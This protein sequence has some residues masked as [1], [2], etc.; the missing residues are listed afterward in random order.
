MQRICEILNS[1]KN[2]QK[3][4]KLTLKKKNKIISPRSLLVSLSATREELRLIRRLR[5]VASAISGVKPAWRSLLGAMQPRS[6]L[7]CIGAIKGIYEQASWLGNF[8]QQEKR[9]FCAVCVANPREPV[10][11]SLIATAQQSGASISLIA[12]PFVCPSEERLRGEGDAVP[13]KKL[14]TFGRQRWKPKFPW[15]AQRIIK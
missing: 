7:N 1:E 4:N 12:L 2:A 3:C 11:I 8:H 13:S 6:L 5:G 15:G 9:V 14:P 10:S